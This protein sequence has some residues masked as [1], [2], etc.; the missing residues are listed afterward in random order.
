MS[1][2]R[3][4]L[5]A[6]VVIPTYNRRDELAQTLETLT[7]Q[8]IDPREFE[9]VVADDGSSDDSA[10]VVRSFAGRLRVKYFFQPDE[11]FRAAAARNGGARLAS[12]P[13]LIFLD[14]GTLAGPGLVS[15]HLAVHAGRAERCAVMGY[16]Y[17]YNALREEQWDPDS[18]CALR[19]AE[20]VRHNRDNPLFA[21]VRSVD[22]SRGG[23]DPMQWPIPWMYFF[24]G[25]CSMPARDFWAVGGF[26]EKF[27]SWGVEDLDLGYRLF[28]SGSAM[29]LTHDAWALE[30]PKQRPVKRLLYSLMRNGRMFLAK[31]QEP[32]AEIL[33][34]AYLSVRLATIWDEG[35]ALRR[36]T[37]EA[38]D[39]E[40]RAEIETAAAGLGADDDLVV[41][42]CGPSVPEW[43]PAATLA[44]FDAD[45]LAQATAGGT[46]T[47]RHTIGLRTA[48]PSKSADV[49]IVTSRL[50]GLWDCFGDQIVREANRIG[51][52]VVV[53][54]RNYDARPLTLPG[55]AGRR[56]W[57]SSP[58]SRASRRCPDSSRRATG[59]RRSWP[60][61]TSR[62]RARS[63]ATGCWP[64]S[65]RVPPR[66][67]PS[68]GTSPP[69]PGRRRTRGRRPRSC[70]RSKRGRRSPTATPSPSRRPS[71][72]TTGCRAR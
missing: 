26:D 19:P 4:T 43:L 8:D 7:E 62:W 30:L 57:T 65:I 63:T 32:Y 72:G 29:A 9:V 20:I 2:S 64:T 45:L 70:G 69:G 33:A 53:M 31:H 10:D 56:R 28:H 52:R 24:S 39:L 11:G 41:F 49:V 22:F 44:D 51:R 54:L 25:N 38:R 21:D 36:W 58:P 66:V 50:R 46:H 68:T 13:L 40:V 3:D 17:G 16:C 59:M 37:Q 61:R 1:E 60:S 15:G 12:A 5:Q 48:L 14:S 34:D 55:R 23:D 71:P 67:S 42:G 35:L 47:A 18:F 6:S 27:R